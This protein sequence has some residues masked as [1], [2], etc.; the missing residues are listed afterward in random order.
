MTKSIDNGQESLGGSNSENQLT[1]PNQISNQI[2][3]WTQILE[4]KENDSIIKMRQEIDNKFETILTKIKNNRSVSTVTN[5]R[6][7][8]NGT[9]DTQQS[10]SKPNRSIGVH[11]SNNIFSY[12]EE[13]D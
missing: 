3:V 4:Q 5:H 7:E 6:S 1:E 9:Q 8:T 10:G 11:A 2:H 13:K 12:L